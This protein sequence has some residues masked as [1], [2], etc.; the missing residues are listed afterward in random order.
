MFLGSLRGNTHLPEN[1][2]MVDAGF[3]VPFDGWTHRRL[4][5]YTMLLVCFQELLK[6]GNNGQGCSF[7]F[8]FS[9]LFSWHSV[10]FHLDSENCN[11]PQKPTHRYLFK[12]EITLSP[13]KMSKY[14]F[15]PSLKI[16]KYFT[17]LKMR[18]ENQSIKFPFARTH[19]TGF[20]LLDCLK[21]GKF[22]EFSYKGTQLT[23]TVGSKYFQVHI[24]LKVA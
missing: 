13:L 15:T 11:L 24:D 10:R 2:L 9:L 20:F 3:Q 19:G 12:E 22:M 17:N 16:I 7:T 5:L 6:S 14:C 4:S 21:W 1:P 18:V 8:L 23:L